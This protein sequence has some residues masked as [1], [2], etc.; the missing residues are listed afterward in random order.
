MIK[1]TF[2]LRLSEK[3]KEAK[4][5]RAKIAELTE[6]TESNVGAWERDQYLPDLNKLIILSDLFKVSIDW[7]LCRPIADKTGVYDYRYSPEMMRLVDRFALIPPFQ[8]DNIRSMIDALALPFDQRYQDWERRT[9]AAPLT[10]LT[11]PHKTQKKPRKTTN[12]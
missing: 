4:L 12:N 7:L 6:T 8:Q 9:P 11:A 10:K 1:Q 3:R 2:G 5:S